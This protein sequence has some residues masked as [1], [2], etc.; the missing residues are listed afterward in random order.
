MTDGSALLVVD[1][2]YGGGGGRDGLATPTTLTDD[3]FGVEDTTLVLL[4]LAVDATGC[5]EETLASSADAYPVLLSISLKAR[6]SRFKRRSRSRLRASGVTSRTVTWLA[7]WPR[8]D[9]ARGGL[10]AV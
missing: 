8:A 6:S 4:A 9:G 5:T 1:A 10:I 7:T 3:W 2:V